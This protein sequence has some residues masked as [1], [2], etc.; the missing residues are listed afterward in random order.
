MKWKVQQYKL[1]WEHICSTCL[2]DNEWCTNWSCTIAFDVCVYLKLHEANKNG[3][4]TNNGRTTNFH[5]MGTIMHWCI[6]PAHLISWHLHLS[7]TWS[8]HRFLIHNYF[9]VVYTIIITFQ[10]YVYRIGR[11]QWMRNHHEILA[12]EDLCVQHWLWVPHSL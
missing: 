8:H 1:T 4:T 2:L 6:R 12:T 11:E 5:A 10:Y 7:S 3:Q 9:V